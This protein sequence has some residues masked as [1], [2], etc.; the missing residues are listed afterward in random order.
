M[1]LSNLV[2]CLDRTV[3]LSL[4]LTPVQ[5][6]VLPGC[7]RGCWP[8]SPRP[9]TLRTLAHRSEQ[10]P[11][12]TR[13]CPPAHL[14]SPRFP[15]TL[16][17]AFMSSEPNRGKRHCVLRRGQSCHLSMELGAG[18]VR[19]WLSALKSEIPRSFHH[20]VWGKKEFAGDTAL[21]MAS[22]VLAPAT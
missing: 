20:R 18:G 7:G 16:H 3:A 21:P 22:W 4:Q 10:G 11:R 14:P 8:P 19:V 9:R 2:P 12:P 17:I 5:V 15:L 13:F 6:L 1:F